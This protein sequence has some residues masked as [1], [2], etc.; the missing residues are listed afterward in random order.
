M[1][2]KEIQSADQ[3]TLEAAIAIYDGTK[4]VMTDV[5]DGLAAE[6]QEL[7][8]EVLASNGNAAA[9]PKGTT[10]REWVD[11]M[12]ATG[13]L[14]M[15][16]VGWHSDLEAVRAVREAEAANVPVIYPDDG[17]PESANGSEGEDPRAAALRA[18][19]VHERFRGPGGYLEQRKQILEA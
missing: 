8:D 11:E 1:N 9:P 18:L 14:A 12:N 7:Y 3:A 17:S 10:F 5:T 13:A 4:W 16:P 15:P 2:V 6:C 19:P